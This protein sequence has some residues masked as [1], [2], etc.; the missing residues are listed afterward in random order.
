LPVYCRDNV[1]EKYWSLWHFFRG[2][3]FQLWSLTSPS[4]RYTPAWELYKLTAKSYILEYTKDPHYYL[5]KE[6]ERSLMHVMVA[7]SATA[8]RAEK[9]FMRAD[10]LP[11]FEGG[12]EDII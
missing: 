1:Y 2:E 12:R 11:V 7:P 4:A 6:K 3:E 8:P 5:L 9:V 10:F